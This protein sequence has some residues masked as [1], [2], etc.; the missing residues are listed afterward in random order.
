MVAPQ[1]N[2]TAEPAEEWH[3]EF[4]EGCVMLVLFFE[5]AEDRFAIGLRDSCVTFLIP[6]QTWNTVKLV[7][8]ES[9]GAI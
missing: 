7:R 1:L 8:I 2:L 6:D 9:I 3:A 5:N 4:A